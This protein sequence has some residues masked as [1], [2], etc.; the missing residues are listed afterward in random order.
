[1]LTRRVCNSFKS[2]RLHAI[3]QNGILWALLTLVLPHFCAVMRSFL[4]SGDWFSSFFRG[5]FPTVENRQRGRF[6]DHRR[7]AF[8]DNALGALLVHPENQWIEARLPHY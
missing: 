8:G 1:M 5:P 3:G 4:R 2:I 6:P 7:P